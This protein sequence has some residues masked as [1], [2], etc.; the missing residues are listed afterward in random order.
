MLGKVFR[1]DDINLLFGESGVGKTISSIKA[2]NKE[3]I[4]PILL[5]FDYNDS[6]ESNNCEYIHIDGY[7]FIE[8]KKSNIPSNEVIVVDT[9]QTFLDAGGDIK[10]LNSIRD[11]NN[12]VILIAHNKAIATKQDIPDIDAKYANHFGSKLWLERIYS[13]KENKV[14][15]ILHVKKCRGYKGSPVINDWQRDDKII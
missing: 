12:T 14:H 2:L 11:N 9:W 4:T 6:Q 1:K 15:S 10:I 7:Q 8:D 13:K 3:G 5:D